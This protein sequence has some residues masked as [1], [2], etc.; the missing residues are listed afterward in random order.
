MHGL[1]K[2]TYS[3]DNCWCPCRSSI[4]IT[5]QGSFFSWWKN[6]GSPP[7]HTALA[8]QSPSILGTG[9]F[10]QNSQEK[11]PLLILS[12]HQYPI[13]HF[14]IIWSGKWVLAEDGGHLIGRADPS[15][16]CLWPRWLVPGNLGAK[17]KSLFEWKWSILYFLGADLLSP[18][19]H[20]FT[21][22]ANLAFQRLFIIFLFSLPFLVLSVFVLILFP[23]SLILITLLT[24]SGD[25]GIGCYIDALWIL[26]FLYV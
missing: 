17:C 3:G 22:C 20:T 16:S 24:S 4:D 23:S 26:A 18:S 9:R 10:W 7:C 2:L 13:N 8:S 11:Y 14:S 25:L 12:A 15:L 1:V 6:V 21:K 5:R 19:G